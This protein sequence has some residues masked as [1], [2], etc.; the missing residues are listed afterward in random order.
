VRRCFDIDVLAAARVI[1]AAQA[2]VG[3]LLEGM[4][5]AGTLPPSILLTGP[6][7]SGKELCAIEIAAMLNCDGPAGGCDPRC[8]SCNTVST[9]EHP[10]LH[11]VFPVPYREAEK[12]TRIV[13]ESRREDFFASGEFGNR[14]RSIGIDLVRGVIEAVSKQ[15]YEGKYSVV[16]VFEAHLATA[17]AQN[18]VL[19]LL[20]EPPPS[21]VFVLVTSF[22]DRLLPTVLSRCR[23]VRTEPLSAGTIAAFLRTFY[24]VEQEESERLASLAAGNVRRGVRFLDERFQGMRRDALSLIRLAYTGRARELLAESETIARGYS[25]DEVEQLLEEAVIVVR[26]LMRGTVPGD[27]SETPA[28]KGVA[29][30]G[31]ASERRDLPR[32]LVRIQRATGNLRRN[33][34]VELTLSHLLLDLAGKWY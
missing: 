30:I 22:P 31:R 18:A 1:M 24:S 3:S 25:R 6:E 7:G 9:L 16:I 32:D 2:R 14:A 8:R 19:K 17:E 33:V 10:D 27:T 23:E 20:E 26:D 4:V 5:L 34:D 12:G 29:E 11:L 21:S 28:E 13:T 15:P